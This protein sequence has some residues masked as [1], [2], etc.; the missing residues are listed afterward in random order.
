LATAALPAIL[1]LMTAGSVSPDIA[2]SVVVPVFDQES[3]I[4]E[5]VRLIRD[6][7][8]AGLDGKVEVIVVSDGSIDQTVERL[9]ESGIPNVRVL[10][11]DRNLGKGYA[12]KIGALEARGRWVGYVDADLDLDPAALPGFVEVAEREDLDFVI[13]SKRHPLSK[14]HYP[15]SRVVASWLFQQVVRVLFDL[16][17]RDTQVGLK[18]FSH[19]IADDVMPLLLVKRYAFDVE[20][21]AVSRAFGFARIRE[22]PIKLD[23]QFT[24][25]GVRSVAVLHALVDTAAIFYRL[26]VLRY[27]QRRRGIGEKSAWARPE[28]TEPDVQMIVRS[29][30]DHDRRAAEHA[31]A[32]ILAF[33]EPGSRPSANWLSATTPFLATP[34]LAAVVTPQLAPPGGNARERAAA[35]I[36][37]SRVGAGSLHFRFT[38]GMIRFVS[39]FP[40]RSVVVRRERYLALPPS[41]TPEM[42]VLELVAGGG[43]VLYVPEASVTVPAAPLFSGHL[44]R[45]TSYGRSR[46]ALVRR[47]RL[48][49]IRPSTVGAVGLLAW[50]LLG[51]VLV[52]GGRLAFEA[53]AAVWG[54]YIVVVLVAAGFGGLR[55]GSLRV[56]ALTAVGLPLT[57]GAYALGFVSGFAR[58]GTH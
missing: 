28:R 46:G 36:S 9:L 56:A 41:T 19:R 30:T 31:G 26:R 35:A 12:V 51:W 52:L 34:D 43:R 24:G 23:Y 10:H 17:V 57:H 38:P 42:E 16:E 15:R 22:M 48:A 54:V 14:V 25:S 4:A 39:D 13:G 1:A 45:I 8:A 58:P 7:A 3:V 5:N 11:Y 27:Y 44:H 40:A 53:W 18:V 32:E 50:A 47:R 21:L 55:F 33:L 37:E 20:L 49:A 2:L 29:G 6:R